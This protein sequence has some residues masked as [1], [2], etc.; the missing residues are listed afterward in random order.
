MLARMR[1]MVSPHRPSGERRMQIQADSLLDGRRISALQIRVFA[2]CGLVA[3]VDAVDSQAIGVA[4]PLMS[5]SL[6]M[7]AAAFAPAYSAGL[8]GA[9][10]GA[11]AFGPVSDRFGRKPTLVF[12]TLLFGI[13]TVLTASAISFPVLFAYR[14]IAGLGLGGAT[15]CFITMAAEYAPQKSRAMYV[16]LLW[17]GYPLGNSVGGVLTS[18]LVA[19]FDWPVIF[20]VAGTPT[21]LLAV[22]MLA[23]LPESLRFLASTGQ[24]T[25]AGR[26]ARKLD[27]ELPGSVEVVAPV[28][29]RT[30]KIPLRD[31]FTDG[32]APTT[33]L[34]GLMLYF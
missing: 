33:I 18:F 32:R 29:A 7:S 21:I 3:L 27:P 34:V 9:A 12:T 8:L 20:V 16:S 19:R 25:R 5:A 31:L 28:R 11:L 4:G 2:F 10:I 23:F 26:V 24:T 13:F 14:L 22:A 15:P 1:D 30:A 17:A 6:K